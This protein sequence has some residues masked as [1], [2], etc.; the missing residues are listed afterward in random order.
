MDKRINLELR[1]RQ[2]ATVSRHP[3]RAGKK[4]LTSEKQCLTTKHV[5]NG[6]ISKIRGLLAAYNYFPPFFRG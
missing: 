1:G 5:N 2:P 3:V 6:P 4:V